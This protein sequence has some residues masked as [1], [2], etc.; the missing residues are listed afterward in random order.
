[1]FMQITKVKKIKQHNTKY[2]NEKQPHSVQRYLSGAMK[3]WQHQ[4]PISKRFY[5]PKI[6]YLENYVALTWKIKVWSGH[7]F[8]YAMTAEL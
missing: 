4:G 5:E 2:C 7:K 6:Q 3:T 8:A 1:M